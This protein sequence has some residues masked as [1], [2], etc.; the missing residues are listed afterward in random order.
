MSDQ[1]EIKTNDTY[2]PLRR[3]IVSMQTGEPINLT[4]ASARF[5][6]RN[7]AED[8]VIDAAA[9]IESPPTAGIVRYEWQAEDTTLPGIF[10]GEF[11]ITLSGGDILT[12]PTGKNYIKIVIGE[13]IA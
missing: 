4:S 8:V 5:H 2:P 10:C 9:S 1:V 3:R 11:E 12:A 13:D 7:I 6:M